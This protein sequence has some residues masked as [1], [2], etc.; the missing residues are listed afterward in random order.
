MSTFSFLE[1]NSDNVPDASSMRFGIVVTEWNKHITDA[2]LKSALETLVEYGVQENSITI[3]RVPGSF[4]LIYGCSQLAQH[5]YI[6]AIIALGC[7]IK[8]DTPHFDYICEG[9]TEGLVRL[10]ATGKIPV[11]NGILTVNTEEQAI[12][13]A[14]RTMDKGREFAITAIKMVDFM[15]S[16]E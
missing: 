15:K 9:T 14:L 2:M 10:N 13:R 8:G 1:N 12:D 4:E 3:R 5:G 16:F 11:I 7:V 6:D